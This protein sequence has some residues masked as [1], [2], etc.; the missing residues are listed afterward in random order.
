MNAVRSG[1]AWRFRKTCIF[2]LYMY[3]VLVF[4]HK[5]RQYKGFNHISAFSAKLYG[6]TEDETTSTEP[7]GSESTDSS[8]TTVIAA[9]SP[10]CSTDGQQAGSEG[11]SRHSSWPTKTTATTTVSAGISL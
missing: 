2:H 1:K 8:V 6:D 9:E 4:I 10:T 7:T 3:N 5:S 11:S